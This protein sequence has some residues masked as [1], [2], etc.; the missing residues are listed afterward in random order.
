[1]EG[2]MS[3]MS[4]DH[5]RL[6]AI[7]TKIRTERDAAQAS[8]LYAQF[9]AGLRRHIEWEEKILFP[10]FEV[11]MGMVDSGPT[12]VMR[13]E[14]RQIKIHLE[15]IGTTLATDDVVRAIER[16]IG[17]LGPHNQ[18]EEAV[19]YPWLDRSLPE[20]EVSEVLARMKSSPA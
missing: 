18:K 13:N 11:K 17:V 20:A 5:D 10:P 6:D 16:L 12:F 2:V 1:M 19:L 14:H 3:F 4:Q 7:L 8:E 9:A 15:E